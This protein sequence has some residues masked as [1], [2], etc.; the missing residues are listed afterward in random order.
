M[1]DI[2]VEPQMYA[3]NVRITVDINC[4]S[5]VSFGVYI[6]HESINRVKNCTYNRFTPKNKKL[7]C[8]INTKIICYAC[9]II[10][11]LI[12]IQVLQ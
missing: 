7:D 10:T 6:K 1:A 5:I 2:I 9:W 11:S 4:E 3:K 12:H 8:N